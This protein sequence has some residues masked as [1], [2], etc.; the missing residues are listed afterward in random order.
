[1]LIHNFRYNTM[2]FGGNPFGKTSNTNSNPFGNSSNPFGGNS[3]GNSGGSACESGTN[4]KNLDL[5]F[6][7]YSNS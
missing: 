2:A 7:I 4:C 3:G 6:L 5:L 1:M